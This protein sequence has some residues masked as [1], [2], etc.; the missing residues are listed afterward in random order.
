MRGRAGLQQVRGLPDPPPPALPL[1]AAAATEAERRQG[2]SFPSSADARVVPKEADGGFPSS[3]Q[4][5]VGAAEVPR[6]DPLRRSRPSAAPRFHVTFWSLPL[7]VRRA[8]PGPVRGCQGNPSDACHGGQ[9]LGG[10]RRQGSARGAREQLTM[11]PHSKR[12]AGAW[13]AGKG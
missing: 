12:R 5:S 2:G 11:E 10:R 3:G 6:A 9:A 1:P 7:A 4:G 8:P 13:G